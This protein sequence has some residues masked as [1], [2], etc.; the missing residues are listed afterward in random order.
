MTHHHQ[1]HQDESAGGVVCAGEKKKDID[2]TKSCKKLK[3]KNQEI[4]RTNHESE[5]IK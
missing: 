3:K 2:V 1:F 5:V 4:E